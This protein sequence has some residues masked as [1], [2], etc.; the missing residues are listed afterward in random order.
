MNDLGPRSSARGGCTW[1][2]GWSYWFNRVTLALILSAATAPASLNSILRLTSVFTGRP[3]LE[4][5]LELDELLELEE[6]LLELEEE[7]LELEEELLE[8]KEE[9]LELDEELLELDEELLELDEELLELEEELELMA[10][11]LDDFPLPQPTIQ[12]TLKNASTA[13]SL[14]FVNI[15]NLPFRSKERSIT[16]CLIH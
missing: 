14:G 3:E 6:E 15:V 11:G 13:P 4:E 8:S 2:I 10:G 9:P 16:A 1:A 12:N 7:L 5:L